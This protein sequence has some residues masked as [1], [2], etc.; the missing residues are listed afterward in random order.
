TASPTFDIVL[1]HGL[2]GGVFKTWR[3][4]DVRKQTTDY[5]DC[6]PKSW[7]ASDFPDS[8]ILAVNYQTF[9]SNWTINCGHA[10]TLKERSLQL[11]HDLRCANVGERPII[12]ITHSMGGL[13]IKE[14]LSQIDCGELK[15]QTQ[16]LLDQTKGIVFFS[17]PHA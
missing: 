1:V 2:Q 9:L 16:S 12:W 5:T 14:M 7:L 17:V 6:W 15:E 4:S 3:Q 13:L 8:R 11:A 10:H